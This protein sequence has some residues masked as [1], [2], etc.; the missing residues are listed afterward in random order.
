[1]SVDPHATHA[2]ARAMAQPPAAEPWSGAGS[3]TAP[4]TPAGPGPADPVPAGP[5]APA[6]PPAHGPRRAASRRR[7]PLVVAVIALV[8]AVA[9]GVYLLV[10]ARAWSERAAQLEE[11]AQTLGT[12]LAQSRAELTDADHALTTTQDQLEAAQE[13]I[14]ELAD[15]V[16]QTGDDREIQRQLADYQARVSSAATAVALAMDDCVRGQQQLI[17]YLDDAAAYDPTELADFRTRVGEFCTA[18]TEANDEL[19]RQVGE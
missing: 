12:E 8:L 11:S 18:A 19:Q 5:G 14:A 15:R 9:A 7:W 16:A 10:L 6:G 17:G 3:P 2:P 13:Q 4:A 1:M